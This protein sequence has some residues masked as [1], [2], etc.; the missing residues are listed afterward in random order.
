MTGY[1]E[2]DNAGEGSSR[3]LPASRQT[4]PAPAPEEQQ[5][6]QQQPASY[7][8]R[9]RTQATNLP[10]EKTI[11]LLLDGSNLAR[12][13]RQ[14]EYRLR[15][16]RIH[17]VADYKLPRPEETDPDYDIWEYWSRIACGWIESLLDQE[18]ITILE[19]GVDTFPSRANDTMREVETLVRRADNVRR[20][21]IKFHNMKRSDF[22]S[23]DA[24]II[25]YLAQYNQ[26]VLH[27]VEPHP[28]GAMFVML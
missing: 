4:S 13:K 2:D 23:A 24:F 26:L 16:I 1:G 7:V 20:Q 22:S 21:V 9:P 15:M 8:I 28:F 17:E 19:S 6:K 5:Q 18:I 14:I 12:W 10:E 11:K 3:S 27:K 25:A